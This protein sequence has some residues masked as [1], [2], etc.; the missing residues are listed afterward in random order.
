MNPQYPPREPA[1]GHGIN[2]A[3]EN[4]LEEI[5]RWIGELATAKPAGT[6]VLQPQKWSLRDVFT[7]RAG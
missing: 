5:P 6:A 7:G 1:V 2:A 3:F 4:P